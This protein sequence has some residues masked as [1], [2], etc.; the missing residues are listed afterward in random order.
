MSRRVLVVRFRA[1]GDCV[2]AAYPVT[3][4]RNAMPDAFM[5]WAVEPGCTAVI[6]RSELV[7]RV[8]HFP[9]NRWKKQG[10][11]RT[12]P[13]Q[14]RHYLRLRKFKFDL[15]IDFQGHSKTA[16]ALKLSGAKQRLAVRATDV[17]AQNLNPVAKIDPS[18]EHMVERHMAALNTLGAFQCPEYPLM[19]QRLPVPGGILDR[20]FVSLMTGASSKNKLYSPDHWKVVGNDLVKKGIPVVFVGGP[21]DPQPEVSG[22]I[23]LVGKLRLRETMAVLRASAVHCAPDTGTGH[24]AAAYGVP[25]VSLF[26]RRGHGPNEFRPYSPQVTVLQ[27]TGHVDEI[28]PM[29]VSITIFDTFSANLL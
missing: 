23:N 20:P 25:V 8:V 27:G 22:A 7:D 4:L 15:A 18:I 1:I 12:F 24:I 9:R 29:T 5:V 16:L 14:L 11:I 17:L 19:P 10:E 13:D 21:T 2:M 28:D 6:D 3:A 26:G